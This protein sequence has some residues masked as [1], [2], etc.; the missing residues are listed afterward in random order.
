MSPSIHSQVVPVQHREQRR[1][2]GELSSVAGWVL[3]GTLITFGTLSLLTVGIPFV[4]IGFA[5]NAVSN[6]SAGANI[7]LRI[8]A[9]L[10]GAG[11]APLALSFL[12]PSAAIAALFGA[13]GLVLSLSGGY[14]LALRMRRGRT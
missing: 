3:T 5:V 11:I 10:A 12:I 6:R 4:L 1:S 14:A 9:Y 7:V 8:P 2:V 13:L